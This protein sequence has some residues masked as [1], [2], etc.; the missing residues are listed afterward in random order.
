MKKLE[1][2]SDKN[3]IICRLIFWLY[4]KIVWREWNKEQSDKCRVYDNNG[5]IDTLGY[6]TSNGR[7]T[8]HYSDEI[9][10]VYGIKV[11]NLEIESID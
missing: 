10:C 11:F 6:N 9:H 3:P 7:F 5:M 2:S 8:Y 4:L 1:F